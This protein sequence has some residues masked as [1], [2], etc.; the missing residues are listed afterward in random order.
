MWY[1]RHLLALA[2]LEWQRS[3]ASLEWQRTAHLDALVLE[4]WLSERRPPTAQLCSAPH[5][6]VNVCLAHRCSV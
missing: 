6:D 1:V 2:S 4:Q 3:L 5:D